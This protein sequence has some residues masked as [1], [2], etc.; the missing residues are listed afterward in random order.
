VSQSFFHTHRE[1]LAKA[2]EAIHTRTYWSAYPEI[3]SGK[4][5]GETARDD[6]Q[7]AFES[8]LNRPFELAGHPGAAGGI[9]AEISPFGMALGVTYP[10]VQLDSAST[11]ERKGAGITARVRVGNP[12][13]TIAFFVNLAITKNEGGMEVAPCFWNEN[14][15]CLLPGESKEYTAALAVNDLE[16][17]QPVL[18]VTGWNVAP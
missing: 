6:G 12:G 15:F 18:R 14:D 9:G 13:K 17:A 11:F 4:F 2:V 1:L 7:K 10:K 3:P 8:R 5:Y 16:G